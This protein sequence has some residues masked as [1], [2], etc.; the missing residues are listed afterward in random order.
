MGFIIF[1]KLY[2]YEHST[3]LENIYHPPNKNPV[4]ISSHSSFSHTSP[5]QAPVNC[6]YICL[7]WRFHILH[8][9]PCIMCT[10]VLGPNFQ[11]KLSF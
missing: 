5:M 10:H 11:E 7:F 4:P 2:N 9:L 3:I 1:A 6:F 8:I